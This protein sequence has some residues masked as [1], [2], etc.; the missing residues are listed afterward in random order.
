MK[1]QIYIIWGNNAFE[2]WIGCR[3]GYDI[4]ALRVKQCELQQTILVSCSSN[5]NT[6][7]ITFAIFTKWQK[8]YF[9]LLFLSLTLN[10]LPCCL[11]RV[12]RGCLNDH[13]KWDQLWVY[14]PKHVRHDSSYDSDNMT[15]FRQVHLDF[16][17]TK[18]VFLFVERWTVIA[19][20]TLR[21]FVELF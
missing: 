19:Y 11:H 18:F 7:R 12:P 6:D 21:C 17:G 8:Y 3:K 1:E 2:R 4:I 9:I 14:L 16:Q 13:A 10:V 20:L 5:S 15:H